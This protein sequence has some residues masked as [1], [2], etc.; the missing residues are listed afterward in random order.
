MSE[1]KKNN[2]FKSKILGSNI[3]YMRR[4]AKYTQ[5]KFSEKVGITPQFLSSVERG[6]AGISIETAI[7][8]CNVSNCSA[9]VLFK[10]IVNTNNIIDKYDLL[11]DYN[12][13]VIDKM[14]EF[15]LE[16]N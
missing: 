12:K 2:E 8:L 16:N 15:L 14:I 6:N 13:K 3:K 7:K 5:E 11:N 9:N 10:D 4:K 1:I